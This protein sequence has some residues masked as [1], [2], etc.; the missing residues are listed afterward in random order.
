[1]DSRCKFCG[2]PFDLDEFHGHKSPWEVWVKAFY[3]YGCGAV[4]AL[5]DELPP[6]KSTKCSNAPILNEEA[7]DAVGMI[8]ELLGDDYDGACTMID[9]HVR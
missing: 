2:E 4:D 6:S 9:D 1:M 8:Q 5:F 7:M 3:R